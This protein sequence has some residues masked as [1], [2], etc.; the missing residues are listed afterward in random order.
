MKVLK[1]TDIES[2]KHWWFEHEE[3]F[4][5]LAKLFP[6]YWSVSSTATVERLFS[7]AS[8]LC[9]PARAKMSAELLEALVVVKYTQ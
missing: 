3:Q 4:P 7:I 1:S 5:R 6:V 9:R 8:R 2:S